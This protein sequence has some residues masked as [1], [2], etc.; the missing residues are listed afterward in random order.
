[1]C[2][3]Q[4]VL[5]VLNPPVPTDEYKREQHESTCVLKLFLSSV[6]KNSYN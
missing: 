1:M 6:D 4:I 2:N 3:F 5:P